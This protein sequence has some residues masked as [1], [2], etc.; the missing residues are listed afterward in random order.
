MYG[1]YRWANG[2]KLWQEAKVEEK[3]RDRKVHGGNDKEGMEVGNPSLL[4]KSIML[5]MHV[6]YRDHCLHKAR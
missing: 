4:K 1:K 5:P 2:G 6:A 3:R